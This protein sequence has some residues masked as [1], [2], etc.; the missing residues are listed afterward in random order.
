MI[1]RLLLRDLRVS[2][3]GPRHDDLVSAFCCGCGGGSRGYAGVGGEFVGDG[4][5][6]DATSLL[7]G[8]EL[9]R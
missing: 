2:F 1:L 7:G 8:G 4:K 5:R 3:R 6:A 9:Y